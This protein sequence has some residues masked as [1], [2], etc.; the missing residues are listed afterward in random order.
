MIPYR[1]LSNDS[2]V[3]AFEIGAAHIDVQFRGG[4]VYRYTVQSVGEANL[5]TMKA[6]AEAGDGLNSFINKNVR[7]L[8]SEKIR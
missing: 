2:G 1:D 3:E 7:K 5:N 8:F 6:L 4:S